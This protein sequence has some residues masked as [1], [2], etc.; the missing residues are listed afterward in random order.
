MYDCVGIV[1]PVESKHYDYQKYI[2]NADGA[3]FYAVFEIFSSC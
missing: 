1:M 2:K 3:N